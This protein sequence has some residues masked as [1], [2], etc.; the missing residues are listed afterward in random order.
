M[1]IEV[2]M[3]DPIGL[4][5]A[6]PWV[7]GAVG[8]IGRTGPTGGYT[9]FKAE[10]DGHTLY[11]ALIPYQGYNNVFGEHRRVLVEVGRVIER[12]GIPDDA[13]E[14]A[15]VPKSHPD[16]WLSVRFENPDDALAFRT[17]V[18]LPFQTSV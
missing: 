9:P 3:G 5:P 10:A 15:L 11:L 18:G 7:A 6:Q 12:L 17:A 16:T 8:P 1:G 4:V 2:V 14:I 13:V